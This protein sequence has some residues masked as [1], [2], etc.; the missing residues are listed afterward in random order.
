[1]GRTLTEEQK[2]KMNLARKKNPPRV[3]KMLQINEDYRVYS[4]RVQFTIE[5]RNVTELGKEYWKVIGY[6]GNM[7]SLV[8]S[9]GNHITKDNFP[10]LVIIA[11]M[12][13]DLGE[14]ITEL[15]NL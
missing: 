12:I 10:D 15:K 3:R 1:M 11:N 9:L 4:D 13:R 6:H 14:K 5:Q 2:A 7:D 8:K